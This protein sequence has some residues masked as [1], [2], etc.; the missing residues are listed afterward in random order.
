MLPRE[1][2]VKGVLNPNIRP[3]SFELNKNIYFKINFDL[4]FRVLRLRKLKIFKLLFPLSCLL[5]SF[6]ENLKPH[7]Q[8]ITSIELLRQFNTH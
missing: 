7:N 1:S 5:T 2:I 4:G 6:L 8:L 3:F